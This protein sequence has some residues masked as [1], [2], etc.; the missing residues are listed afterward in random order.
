MYW[1]L[2][3]NLRGR[4]TLALVFFGRRRRRRELVGLGF[5]LGKVVITIIDSLLCDDN[6]IEKGDNM[7]HYHG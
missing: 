3:L 2:I 1:L 7:M 4:E 5:R 6:I